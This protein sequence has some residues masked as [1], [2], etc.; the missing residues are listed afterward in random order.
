MIKKHKIWFGVIFVLIMMFSMVTVARAEKVNPPLRNDKG[1]LV[2]DLNTRYI[3]ELE[4]DQA[5]KM[6]TVSFSVRNGNPS[7][8]IKFNVCGL[9]VSF[10]DK[11][12]PYRY[13]PDDIS[14]THPYDPARMYNGPADE[15]YQEFEKY[16]HVPNPKFRTSGSPLVQ[17]DAEGRHLGGKISISAVDD[18]ITILPGESTI[19]AKFFFM[20]QNGSDTLSVDMFDFNYVITKKITRLSPYILNNT[21]MMV[22]D[23]NQPTLAF[24]YIV[25]PVASPLFLMNYKQLPPVGLTA[26][27]PGNNR[28]VG[29]YEAASME[30]SYDAAGP[31]SG[32]TPIVLNSP[33]SIF[34]R[35]K[36]IENA[37]SVVGGDTKYGDYKTVFPSLPAEVKFSTNSQTTY[38]VTFDS[39]GG[40]AVPAVT[41]NAGETVAKPA[42]PVMGGYI[43]KNWLLAGVPFDF[44]TPITGDITLAADWE[45]K[46]ISDLDF[47][48]I[49]TPE[50]GFANP[51]M[52]MYRNSTQQFVAIIN[53]DLETTDDVVWSVYNS[54]H[55]ATVDPE[56]GFVTI[57]DEIGTAVLIVTASN[58]LSHS[59]T[60]R[61]L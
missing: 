3:A 12:A 43:F 36:G 23:N 41:V 27:T 53:M 56:T 37:L 61:V 54:I 35:Y 22:L 33:H 5:T 8:S 4:Q 39:A 18:D 49:G 17:N 21:V 40:S 59:I 42:N 30:W 14:D 58:G 29:G 20:P 11:V 6:I 45:L 52:T 24:D 46:T 7:E 48:R 60:L 2:A 10:S 1:A 28:E 38:T 47:L 19:I 15:T 57:L 50:D 32:G 26:G 51:G 34:V 9:L 13:D 25:S 44:N 31:F 55:M 16:C